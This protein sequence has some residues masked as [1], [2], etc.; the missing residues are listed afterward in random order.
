MGSCLLDDDKTADASPKVMVSLVPDSSIALGAE[1]GRSQVAN[2]I[3][4]KAPVKLNVKQVMEACQAA[5]AK[6]EG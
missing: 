4:G 1:A 2:L 6:G 3:D 5:E